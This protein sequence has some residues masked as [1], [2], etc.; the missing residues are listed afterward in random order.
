MGKEGLHELG[1]DRP[2]SSKLTA[3]QA[4]MLN[5]VEEELPSASDVAKADD[6]ELQE[7]MENA[8][9]STGNLITQ[10]DN[11]MHPPGDSFEYP[12]CELLGLDKEL[13]SIRGLL[14]VETAKKIQ[15]EEQIEREKHKLFELQDNPEYNDGTQEDIRNR[16]ER[17]NDNLKVRQESI[18]LLEGRLTNQIMGIKEMIAK[19]LDKG[20]SLAKKIRTLFRE[21]GIMITSILMAIGMAVGVLVEALHPSG[22]G[23]AA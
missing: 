12:L 17:L 23:V 20:T 15:L 10:L 18:N 6:I 1:F 19:V 4:A 13:R 2:K 5:R 16:I 14:K 9:R 11:Q 8:A 3:Q 21:Q 22:G 7:V